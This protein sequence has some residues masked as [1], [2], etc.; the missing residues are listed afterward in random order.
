MAVLEKDWVEKVR[1]EI[2]SEKGRINLQSLAKRY[3]VQYYQV[4]WI[5]DCLINEGSIPDVREDRIYPDK[6]VSHEDRMTLLLKNP[7]NRLLL[8]RW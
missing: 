8:S 3:G 4:Y 6:K 1:G 7:L 2:L 5:R